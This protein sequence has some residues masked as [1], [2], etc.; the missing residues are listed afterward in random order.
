LKMSKVI[1]DWHKDNANL[2][3]RFISWM[4]EGDFIECD[5]HTWEIVEVDNI[6]QNFIIERVDMKDIIVEFSGWVRLSPENARFINVHT[7]N[8]DDIITG[9]EF[10][11]LSENEQQDYI[12]DD[13]IAAQRD[14]HD[15][16]YDEIRWEVAEG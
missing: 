12:L 14:G 1:Y 11:Q 6:N 16:D 15:G 13:I 3:S 8:D 10:Q 4:T 9:V 2:G 7:L 5:G